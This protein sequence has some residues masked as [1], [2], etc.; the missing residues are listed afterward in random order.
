MKREKKQILGNFIN[1]YLLL[2]GIIILTLY[3]IIAEPAF[4]NPGNLLNLIR[5]FVPLAFVSIGMTLIIIG[6]YIDLSVAGLFSMMSILASM[7]SNRFDQ[8][9]CC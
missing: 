7:L 2:T 5:T 9:P 8:F 6:G 1:D 3:T 4:L